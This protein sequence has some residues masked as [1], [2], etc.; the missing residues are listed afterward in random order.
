LTIEFFFDFLPFKFPLQHLVNIQ[1]VQKDMGL[2]TQKQ[3]TCLSVNIQ[4]EIFLFC[5]RLSLHTVC[6]LSKH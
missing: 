6:P 2:T 1:R 3:Q 4:W 5:T